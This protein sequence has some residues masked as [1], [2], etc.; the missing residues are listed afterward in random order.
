[1]FQKQY[2]KGYLSALFGFLL[3]SQQV[4][5]QK[6][7]LCL[8][9]ELHDLQNHAPIAGAQVVLQ[10]GNQ[11]TF[12]DED[13]R[14][15]FNLICSGEYEVWFTAIGYIPLKKRVKINQSEAQLVVHLIPKDID[16]QE[17]EIR[18]QK[19]LQ[20]SITQSET[21]V[22][23]KDLNVRQGQS[24][25]QILQAI[26]G[27][28]AMQSG[29]NIAKPMIHGLTGNRVLIL[30]NGVRH[31]GQQ[32]GNDHAPEI[33]PFMAERITVV[34]GARSVLYG[35][36]ALAGVIL[37]QPPAIDLNDTTIGGDIFSAMQTNGRGGSLSA[38]IHGFTHGWGWLAQGT[39][40]RLGSM[41]TPVYVLE[42]TAQREFNFNVGLG[43]KIG[44]DGVMDV[45]FSGF[46]SRIGI[47]RDAHVGNVSDL[48]RLMDKPDSL[49]QAPFS[50]QFALP[51]QAI[52]HY[53]TRLR[54][55]KMQTRLGK[56]TFQASHQRND[57]AEYDRHGRIGAN[58]NRPALTFILDNY[59]ADAL[60]EK[61]HP[62]NLTSTYGLSLGFQ[63]N[64]QAGRYFVPWFSAPSAGVFLLEKWAHNQWVLEAGLRY[65][66]KQYHISR[67][68]NQPDKQRSL[69][70]QNGTY[71]LGGSYLA[72]EALTLKANI[73]AGWRAPTMPELFAFGVHHA[74]A[75]FEIGDSTLKPERMNG[76]SISA[77][78]QAS[79]WNIDAT[80]YHN[81]FNNFIYLV[82]SGTFI[83]RQN[84]AFPRFD[85]KGVRAQFTGLD[86]HI[87]KELPLGL[88]AS[89][90]LSTMRAWNIDADAP[91]VLMP[92]DRL[93]AT[94]TK[95]LKKQIGVFKYN[96]LSLHWTAA[97]QQHRVPANED[98]AP[99][100]PGY[101]L[102][103]AEWVSEAKMD[104]HHSLFIALGVYNITNEVFR[105]YLN[106]FRYYVYE[107]G[108]NF[109]CRVRYTL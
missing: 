52:K 24:L 10:P 53:V 47:L 27:V 107:P 82:P 33:D 89:A 94:L 68:R 5:G 7:G 104:A 40:K 49:F 21:S 64:I 13:G 109:T 87:Q 48:M 50:Y 59:A 29:S 65:D 73:S 76:A 20:K 8:H 31:E 9:G 97:N 56:L 98:F 92:A 74:S 37:V 80:A 12:T 108:R 44:K 62:H 22:D 14:F 100:P 95:Q 77:I 96:A 38:R 46:N 71:S 2:L 75:S 81:H 51:Y 26:P 91:L 4:I 32:W 99:P 3:W 17:V 54:Y 72:S 18:A 45:Y 6:C 28:Q 60:A 67:F 103:S 90:K 106:R 55:Q 84:G 85:Y 42:N 43:R 34:K 86:L 11:T 66:W 70:F 88:I 78:Y 101:Q 63:Q 105:D 61:H 102:L 39:V 69:S 30:N 41:E 1:L 93:E 19:A 57:R 16:L 58:L 36:D 15:E 23:G 25:A 35:S 83:Q 79:G